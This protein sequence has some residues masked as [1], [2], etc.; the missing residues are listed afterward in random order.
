MQSFNHLMPVH[1]AAN[2]NLTALRG[3]YYASAADCSGPSLQQGMADVQ[4]SA[5][6]DGV[7]AGCEWHTLITKGLAGRSTTTPFSVAA[8]SLQSDS[9]STINLH[10]FHMSTS[11]RQSA[12]LQA[13]RHCLSV[14]CRQRLQG[15]P[16]AACMSQRRASQRRAS[17][18]HIVQQ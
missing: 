10:V 6:K 7:G 9:T 1:Y 5:S 4:L 12:L 17:S 14:Q 8:L 13:V 15:K 3:A 11:C 2:A 16:V 18:M